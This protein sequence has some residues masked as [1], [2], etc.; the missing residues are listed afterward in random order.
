MEFILVSQEELK[1]IENGERKGINTHH[2]TTSEIVRVAKVAFDL[3]KK[4]QIKLLL[5][6]NQM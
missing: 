6:K 4:D 3:A 2:Y 5:V 1:P